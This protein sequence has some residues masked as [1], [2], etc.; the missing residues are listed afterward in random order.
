ME[1]VLNLRGPLSA[2]IAC[3]LLCAAG[4]MPLYAQTAGGTL[5]G[6]IYDQAGKPIQ[7]ATVTVKN[8]SIARTAVSDADGHFSITGLPAGNYTVETTAIGFARNTRGN[9]QVSPTGS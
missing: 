8:D 7:A 9:V 1:R 6:T 2:A 3:I 5:G 4:M